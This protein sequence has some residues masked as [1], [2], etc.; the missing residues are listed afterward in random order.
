LDPNTATTR[1]A[2]CFGMVD[3]A[4]VRSAWDV[5][6]GWGLEGIGDYG[7]FWYQLAVSGNGY[8][9]PAYDTLDDGTAMLTALTK[10]DLDSWCS[11]IRD[12]NLTMTRESW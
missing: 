4:H 11:G 6:A 5:V 10:C 7:A 12:D 8:L 3:Q 2:L 9:S 1:F